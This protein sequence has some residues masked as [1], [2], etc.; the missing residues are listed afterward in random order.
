V[1]S[2]SLTVIAAVGDAPLLGQIRVD[3]AVFTPNGD[4]INDEVALAVEV[5]GLE[6]AKRLQVD[7]H[8]LAGRLVR[9]LS[10]ELGRPSGQHEIRW[11]GRDHGGV[12]VAPGTYAAR[13][14]VPTDARRPGTEA[15]R[16]VGVA[17]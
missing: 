3:P 17:Y 2:S 4:G 9:D 1:G 12:R 13:F 7:I 14:R 11:D 6:G 16:L 10:V 15:V 8:D 5:Y